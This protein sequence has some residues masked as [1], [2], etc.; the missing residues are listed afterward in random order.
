MTSSNAPTTPN[1][2]PF[3]GLMASLLLAPFA[4]AQQ[5]GASR[6]A[7]MTQAQKMLITSLPVFPWLTLAETR[8][9]HVRGPLQQLVN[10]H[11]GYV[12]VTDGVSAET[13]GTFVNLATSSKNGLVGIPGCKIVVLDFGKEDR[14]QLVSLTI[15]RGWRDKNVEPTIAALTS[16]YASITSPIILRD[17]ESEATD[18][19]VLFDIGRFIIEARIP[20]H[21]SAVLVTFTTKEILRQLRTNDR[22]IEHL[23]PILDRSPASR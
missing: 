18:T 10:S 6:S 8:M 16:R 4:Q 11:Q 12:M 5:A 7:G 1:R 2:R 19:T 14:A 17:S 13:G 20:Q 22:T 21:G 15:D 23:R 9:T 3:L